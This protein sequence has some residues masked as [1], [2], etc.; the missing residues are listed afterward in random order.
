MM[1]RV[2]KKQLSE[3]FDRTYECGLENLIISGDFSIIRKDVF[4]YVDQIIK[5]PIYSF[6]EY[7]SENC[8]RLPIVAADVFQF[9]DFDDATQNICYKL[10]ENNNPGLKFKEIA[11]LL[12]NDNIQRS[13]CALN[14]Y[15]E[16]H[17]KTAELIGLAFKD[18][19]KKYYLSSIGYVF[20]ELDEKNKERL[21]IRLIIRNKLISQLLV[22]A[23]QGQ[24]DM[25]AFLY[26][27][28]KS[29]YI[30]RK[31]NI[32]RIINIINSSDEYDFSHI[33]KNIIY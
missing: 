13:D 12:F 1:D 6:V 24:F 19:S 30:R 20:N 18:V 17:I 14:K 15:G 7:I 31:S 33:T 32:K 5:I 10:C 28:S 3:F 27:L 25:E 26:D 11:E 23:L 21:L 8:K 2:L 4:N 9:S 16:N 29:T 22:A